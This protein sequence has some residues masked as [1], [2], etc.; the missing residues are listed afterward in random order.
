[1]HINL[2]ECSQSLSLYSREVKADKVEKHN[3][4]STALRLPIR[5]PHVNRNDSF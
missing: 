1:M 4:S 2:G 5:A 3:G